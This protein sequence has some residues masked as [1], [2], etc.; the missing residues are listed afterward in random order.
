VL[1]FSI[2]SFKPN[3][4]VSSMGKLLFLTH[5]YQVPMG[6]EFVLL[7]AGM[8]I[9]LSFSS[10]G[11]PSGGFLTTLPFYLAAGIPVEAVVLLR[12]VDAI[13]DVFKTVV[14]VTGDLAIAVLA[15]RVVGDAAPGVGVTPG[16]A[17]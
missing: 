10:P 8:L 3:R 13:P 12:A 7:F 16:V 1:P 4:A 2:S 5:V 6:P 17:A 11:I 14:N 15:H 9:L